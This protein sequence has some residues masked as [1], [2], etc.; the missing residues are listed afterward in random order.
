MIHETRVY[1]TSTIIIRNYN[2][3]GASVALTGTP[4]TFCDNPDLVATEGKYAWGA[5]IYFWME[6]SKE[7]TTCHIE[8]LQE[9]GNFGEA[10]TSRKT[11]P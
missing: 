1:L 8:A 7:G 4:D 6:H 3:I 5:G 10:P 11:N 2:Y 9:G